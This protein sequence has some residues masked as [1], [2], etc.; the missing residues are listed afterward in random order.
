MG[1]GRQTVDYWNRVADEKDF[2]F[3]VD[4][5]L[6]ADH[7]ARTAR[8]LDLGCG[9]GRVASLMQRRGFTDVIGFDPAPAMIERGRHNDPTLDLHVW[10]DEHLPLQDGS[11]DGV[12]LVGVLTCIPDAGEQARLLDEAR[13]VLKNDGH[14]YISDIPTQRTERYR[15]RYDKFSEEGTYGTFRLPGDGLLRHFE[16]SRFEELLDG[17]DLVHRRRIETTSMH[18]NPVDI[19]DV[20]GRTCTEDVAEPPD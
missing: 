14:L 15:R 19:I 10:H 12:L 16:P 20:L 4:T 5:D 17:F 8:V 11:I 1:T 3:P 9:Y 13:R 2:T 18:G 6:L 7:L